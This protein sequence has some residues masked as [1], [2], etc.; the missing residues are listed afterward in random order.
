ML[1]SFYSYDFSFKKEEAA[2]AKRSFLLFVPDHCGHWDLPTKKKVI[3]LFNSKFGVKKKSCEGFVKIK[4]KKMH[5]QS[6]PGNYC[7][8]PRHR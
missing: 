8:H 2:A 3:D 6:N 1:F 5:P 4:Y 7:A